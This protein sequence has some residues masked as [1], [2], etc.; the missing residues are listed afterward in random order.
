MV[1]SSVVPDA[2]VKMNSGRRRDASG[3]PCPFRLVFFACLVPLV[4]LAS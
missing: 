3:P 2:V 1:L 4:S